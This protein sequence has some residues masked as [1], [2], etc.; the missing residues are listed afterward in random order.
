[1]PYVADILGVGPIY[2]TFD[3]SPLCM[4]IDRLLQSEMAAK[5]LADTKEAYEDLLRWYEKKV[6]LKDD[7]L[8]YTKL[9]KIVRMLR[10]HD[11]I[12]QVGRE[13]DEL[14]MSDPSSLSAEKLKKYIQSKYDQR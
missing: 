7:V 2:G 13:H 8:I 1:M 14:M 12:R 4:E 3:V 11:K 5:G 6:N 9:E 10:I